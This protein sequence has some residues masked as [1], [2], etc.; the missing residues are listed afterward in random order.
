MVI[1]FKDL[2]TL[3]EEKH[4][5]LIKYRYRNPENEHHNKFEIGTGYLYRGEFW[6]GFHSPFTFPKVFEVIGWSYY[7]STI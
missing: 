5:V 6:V 3:P 1:D 2:T 4:I 7:D